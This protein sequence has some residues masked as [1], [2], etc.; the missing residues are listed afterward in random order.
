[1]GSFELC[2][3]PSGSIKGGNFLTSRVNYLLL[4]KDSAPGLKLVR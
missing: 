4:K 3:E 2:N 1:V